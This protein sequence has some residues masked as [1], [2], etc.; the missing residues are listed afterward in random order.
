MKNIEVSVIVPIYNAENYLD[1]CLSSLVAQDFDKPYEILLVNDGSTDN[2]GKI[3][4]NYARR[5]D[6]IRVFNCENRGVSAARNT[7]LSHAKGRYIAF[8]D[9][10]D[11]VEPSYISVLYALI[12]ENNA[13]ISCCNF[14][15]VKEG[16]RKNHAYKFFHKAGVFASDKMLKSLLIDIGMRS[17]SWGK[18]FRREL[19]ADIKFPE[20]EIFEDVRIMPRLFRKAEK[21]AVTKAPLYNYLLRNSGITGNMTPAKIDG[22]IDAYGAIREYLNNEGI[23]RRFR[24]AFRFLGFKIAL[25]VIPWLVSA[26]SRDKSFTLF[27]EIRKDISRLRTYAK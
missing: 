3:A 26:H 6:K 21:F 8:A 16:D 7:A 2:S 19:F 12:E 11:Y 20:G 1:F 10:D 18:L 23:Y 9:S 24:G 15:T 25:T 4:E 27:A 14:S 17:Y 22:Y 13:D 5:Y